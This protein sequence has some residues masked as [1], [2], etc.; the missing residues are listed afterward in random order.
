M[1]FHRTALFLFFALLASLPLSGETWYIRHDGGTRSSKEHSGQCDGKTDAPYRKGSGQHCAFSDYRYLWDDQTY[2]NDAW[3]IA[4][5][6]TVIIHDGPWRVGWDA[7]TGKGA[8]YTWCLGGGTSGCSNPPIPSGTA[9]HHTR[10]L[11]ENY[12]N[13]GTPEATDRS[14]L[15]QIFGGFGVWTP[16]NLQGAQ[17]V[18]IE[19][20]E[21]AR[22]S[23]C[24]FFGDP[25]VPAP[26]NR[27]GPK[28]DYDSDGVVTDVHTHDLLLQDMWIH[29]H[30][31][32]GV[33]GPIGGLVTC[34]RCDIAYNGGAGWDFDDGNGT[35]SVHATWNFNYSTIE[36]NG[37]N[38]AYPGP[39]AISCYG[40]SNGGY[41]DGVGTP[42]GMCL[43]TNIDHSKFIYNTQDG[44]DLGH[45]D[46]GTDCPL[47]ITN[48]I[49]YG[50]GGGS[51]KWGGN[52]N[53][54]VFTNNIAIGNCVRMSE[55]IPGQPSTFNAHLADFCRAEDALPFDFRQGGTVLF[56][57]NTIVSYAPTTFDIDCWDPSC[58][59]STLTFKNNIVLGYDNPKTYS[60][61]GKP[62]GPGGFYFQKP[63]GH[64]VRSNNL[65]YGLRG[66]RCPTGHAG[67]KC[68]NPQFV[69]QPRFSSE[70][71]LDDFNF[72]LSPTSPARGNGVRIPEV[73]SDYEGKPRPS[74]GNY[75]IG[76]SQH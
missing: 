73:Q 58:S 14:K 10:I 65:F 33:K 15:T 51:F 16:L 66:L 34:T 52:E 76:A 8:G 25:P 1:I 68:E 45:G 57:N 38:Q 20:I 61:G 56:A 12:A 23:Q 43:A 6:D 21:V 72:H 75:D 7:A 4:G 28:D 48:S 32:R 35:P 62:E 54:A 19:C 40:Q 27:G 49:A 11:G 9:A 26:C 42:M 39:G 60:L 31:G 50:N 5:G 44:L 22:H 29:G 17:Y 71:D 59:D 3:V 70:K 2:N 55:P 30:V 41:G 24:V 67:E 13:C 69:S 36:W 37:C 47:T 18:D 53:P 64:I 63:I 74:T 46:K